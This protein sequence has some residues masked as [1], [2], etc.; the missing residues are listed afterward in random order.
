MG[1]NFEFFGPNTQCRTNSDP[2]RVSFDSIWL[3]SSCRPCLLWRDFCCIS[4][5]FAEVWRV[6]VKSNWIEHKFLGVVSWKWNFV[7]LESPKAELQKYHMMYQVNLKIC[8]YR[9]PLKSF[10]IFQEPTSIRSHHSSANDS[11]TCE[12][13]SL[14]IRWGNDKPFKKCHPKNCYS[15]GNTKTNLSTVKGWGP[16]RVSERSSAT[17]LISSALKCKVFGLCRLLLGKGSIKTSWRT[18]V[19]TICQSKAW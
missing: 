8:K 4:I 17:Y 2:Y 19:F 7:I 15:I 5:N 6:P 1:P 13:H 18:L 3:P 11:T 12:E 10:K 14:S 9:V 16:T